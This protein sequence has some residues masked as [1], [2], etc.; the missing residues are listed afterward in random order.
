M[1]KNKTIRH[2]GGDNT[3]PY[4][5]SRL[6]PGISLVDMAR[7]IEQAEKQIHNTSH[8]KLKV[9]AE[10]ILQLKQ[11]AR[12]VLEQAQHDQTLHHAECSFRKIPGKTYHLYARSNGQL[13]FSMLSPADWNYQSSNEYRGSYT[14]L[15][16]MS[17]KAAEKTA[18]ENED[19][20]GLLDSL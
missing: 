13:Y 16:D 1:S 8:A 19:I 14:L 10:Q 18:E 11:Q 15:A 6:S 4:P 17:W 2:Q 20:Q 7:E 12:A 9:I 3:A 5:V